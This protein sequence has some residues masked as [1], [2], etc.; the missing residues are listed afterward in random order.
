MLADPG[1]VLGIPEDEVL[2]GWV[3]TVWYSLLDAQPS[4]AESLTWAWPWRY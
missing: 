1:L 2:Q 4:V 3:G